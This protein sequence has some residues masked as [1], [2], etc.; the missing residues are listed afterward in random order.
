MRIRRGAV[1]TGAGTLALVLLGGPLLGGRALAA[2]P[3]AVV[4]PGDTL[5]AIAARYRTTVARLAAL[6]GLRNPDLIYPGQELVVTGASGS[7]S[8]PSGPAIRIHVVQP[9]ENLTELAA[10]Y[11]TS[12]AAIVATNQLSNPNWIL[13]GQRLRI[14][15]GS[16][17][18][19]AAAA[20]TATVVHVV[21]AGENLTGIARRYRTSVAALVAS[22]HL[23]NASFIRIGQRLLVTVRSNATAQAGWSTVRFSAATRARMARRFPIRNLIVSEA[24]R[25]GVPVPLALAVA[26]QESGWQQ[27]VTSSAGALG[28]MQVMPGTAVWI[29]DAIVHTSVDIH[30]R[31]SNVR[32]GVALLK[33]YLLHYRWDKRRVL[34]AYYQGER[35]VDKYGI[36]PVSRA[37]VA[38]I[39]ELEALFQP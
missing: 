39:L 37:Y 4:R 17:T 2:A 19:R 28:I 33:H 15:D 1:A 32:A 30:N 36:F 11:G 16:H 25:A 5:S 12:V 21:R 7:S 9:G 10:A 22:N 24:Q 38:S 26:W 8:G 34:A 18:R 3:T 23:P 29:A 35:A 31:R 6:N 13:V 27:D 14:A 20:P